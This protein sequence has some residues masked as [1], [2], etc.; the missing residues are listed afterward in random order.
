MDAAASR[1]IVTRS[2]SDNPRQVYLADSSG[3]RLRWLSENA[4]T[5]EHPYGPY[6]AGHVKTVFG[7]LKAADGSTLYTKIM[8]PP[9]EAGKR[10]PV[11]MIHYGGPGAGRQVTNQWDT[12]LYQYLVQ[13][14]WIVYAVD[15]RGTPDRGKAFEDQLYKAM[16]TVEV[17]DQLAGV[18]WLKAQPFV[19][20]DRIATYGWSY[21]GYM[22]LKL[23]QKAS[24][25]FMAGISGAPVTDWG[26]YDTHY[27]ERYLGDP[28]TKDS[29]YPASGALYE[30]TTLKDPLL[31]IHGMSD[32]NVV[33]DNSTAVMARMQG[34][35]V[36][37]ETMVYPG[38]T[39]RVAGPKISV[40]LWRTI[41]DFLDRHTPE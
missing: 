40:H 31:L 15:N 22:T 33:F 11:F 21:G 12:P 41:L 14:G 35:A 34:A 9:L 32:D 23:L 28:N 5:P 38:Q 4:I 8:T 17:E 30:A 2:N 16:G 13:Q 25:V 10:Y 18:A 1:I 26:L 19:D 27:T 6:E 29:A 24:G 37:F 39:H 7:T 20:P 36:P 3:T